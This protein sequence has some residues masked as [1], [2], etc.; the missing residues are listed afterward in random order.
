MKKEA[1]RIIVCSG[2]RSFESG[3][4]GTHLRLLE[5]E[6]KRNRYDYLY[7]MGAT[8][9]SLAL[10]KMK[11]AL[12]SALTGGESRLWYETLIR[13]H[14][15]RDRYLAA[16]KRSIDEVRGSVLVHCHDALSVIAVQNFCSENGI[17]IVYTMHAPFAEGLVSTVG[18]AKG[19][20]GQVGDMI[21]RQVLQGVDAVI[22]VDS[23]E[24]ELAKR[25]GRDTNVH[26]IRNAVDIAELEKLRSNNAAPPLDRP[27]III[28]KHLYEK[29]GVAFALEAYAHS[30]C[31]RDLDLVYVGDG[32]MRASLEARA[33]A[34]GLESRVRFMGKLT[35]GRTLRMIKHAS[36]SCVPSVPVGSYVEATSLT[37]LESMALGVPA[38]ASNVGGLKEILQDTKAGILVPPG[39]TLALASAMDSVASDQALQDQLAAEGIRVINM[40]F[41]SDLWFKQLA[42]VYSRL[43][44]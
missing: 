10:G 17:R 23:W 31:K 29:C 9:T 1:S 3:G 15:L 36:M 19:V 18:E 24:A 4:I 2:H 12:V 35:H 40:K 13:I 20:T 44:G 38:I 30:T 26:V 22:A 14:A 7:L 28:A 43:S 32:A 39:D 41:S 42:R 8:K 37:L 6:L 11:A 25:K 5:R 16:I 21:E 27:Y 34:L 33:R